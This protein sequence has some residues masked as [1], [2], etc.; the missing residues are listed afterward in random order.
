MSA[1]VDWEP[2]VVLIPDHP[3]AALQDVALVADQVRVELEPEEMLLGEALMLTVGAEVLT[4]T[5][6][7]WDA[8]PPKPVQVNV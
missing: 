2:L 1:P 4:E 8:L 6:A 7:D 3:P 5:V